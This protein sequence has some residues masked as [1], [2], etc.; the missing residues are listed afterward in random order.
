M[1]TET[2]RG[3]EIGMPTRKRTARTK[4]ERRRELQCR[5]VGYAVEPY[6]GAV[7]PSRLRSRL[8][9][10]VHITMHLAAWEFS[11]TKDNPGGGRLITTWMRNGDKANN[12]GERREQFVKR[13]LVIATRVK[14]RQNHQVGIGEQPFFGFGTGRF[15]GTGDCAEMLISRDAP[16]MVQAYAREGRYFGIGEDLLARLD[17]Y[18][19]RPLSL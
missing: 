3:Q 13:G 17:A 9:L 7:V 4:L 1:Q 14:N 6:F 16:K 2:D 12:S 15:R 11:G 8:A 19:S 5:A 18:H 10:T